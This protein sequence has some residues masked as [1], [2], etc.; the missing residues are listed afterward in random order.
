[1]RAYFSK[2]DA[3][4]SL[5]QNAPTR[6]LCDDDSALAA[7]CLDRGASA[8]DEPLPLE[9]SKTEAMRCLRDVLPI[10]VVRFC[11]TEGRAQHR[12]RRGPDAAARLLCA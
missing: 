6:S 5:A 3:A 4:L 12:L 2:M 8:I 10:D 1:M 9:D 7:L 11:W